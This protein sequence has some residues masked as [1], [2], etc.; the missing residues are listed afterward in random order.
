MIKPNA[1]VKQ[2]EN[3]ILVG[4]MGSGKTTL[5]KKLAKKTGKSFL[6]LD[7][8]I[9]MQHG[10]TISEIFDSIGEEGFRA[11][12]TEVIRTLKPDSNLVISTGGGAP[13]FNNNMDQLNALGKTVYLEV[14][15]KMLADR[16]FNAKEKR[17]LIAGKSKSELV[18]F[19]ARS[20]KVRGPY[21]AK[22]T[23][24]Y[25]NTSSGVDFE[26]VFGFSGK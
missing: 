15:A 2:N 26:K 11:I 14:P 9:E 5:G 18:D 22:A 17:P 10:K 19:I 16:L 12:E 1:M 24:L 4:F 23:F 6:D 13:C 7:H 25:T 21:Y 8:L 20:L 3:I